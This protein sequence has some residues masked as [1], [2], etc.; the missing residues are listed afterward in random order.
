MHKTTIFIQARL[1]SSRLPGKILKEVCGKP[2]LELMMERVIQNKT[3]DGVVVITTDQHEDDV[4]VN[5]CK[6]KGWDY[7]RGSATNLLER[8]YKA[9]QYFDAKYVVKIPSD[10]PL[11]DPQII[12]K[13]I[14]YFQDRDFDYVSNLH[15]QSYPDGN[16]VEI[17]T[18]E[19]LEYAYL[20]ATKDEDL[21]HTTPYIVNNADVFSIGNVQMN[22]TEDLSSMYRY[23]LDYEEDYLFIKAIYESLYR[24]GNI[25]SLQDILYFISS[26]NHLAEINGKYLGTSWSKPFVNELKV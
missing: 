17:M 18:F 23:T 16:D 25:F 11:I 22:D 8:H 7:Y 24:D 4:I 10:C 21:E 15:P 12:D 5:L 14:Q 26:N 9:A 6:E 19:A 13:V 2:I 3:C 1:G 20:N